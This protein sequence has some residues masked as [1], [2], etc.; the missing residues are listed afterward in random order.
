MFE[1]LLV[2][3][4][5]SEY[6]ERVIA[7][8]NELATKFGS[9]IRVLHVLELGFVGRAGSVPLESHD[10]VHKLVNDTVAQLELAVD[11]DDWWSSGGTARQSGGRDLRR[12]TRCRGDG[13]RCRLPRAHRH[14]GTH[15][16]QYD[17]QAA[18]SFALARSCSSLS[19]RLCARL[20]LADG[21]R[22]DPVRTACS[23][24]SRHSLQDDGVHGPLASLARRLGVVNL[25]SISAAGVNPSDRRAR[26]TFPGS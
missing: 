12:G 4:D 8:A 7:A 18:A 1:K 11:Q 19:N 25:L 13:H 6:K 21:T 15:R 17:A 26:S 5:E 9:E 2:A 24:R 14:R 20:P 22:F 3:V 16:R 23:W 10:D